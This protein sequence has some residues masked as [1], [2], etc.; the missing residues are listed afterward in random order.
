MFVQ[1]APPGQ[2]F[3]VLGAVGVTG[4]DE[5]KVG[6]VFAALQG[7][8]AFEQ[9]GAGHRGELLAKKADGVGRNIARA[10]V[11]Q[12]N[13]HVTGVQVHRVVGGVNADVNVGVF[14]LKRLQPRDEPHRCKRGP[15]G[16]G[17][18]LAPRT[19]ADQAHGAVNALQR[20]HHGAQQLRPRA[21]EL[22]GAGVPQ[23]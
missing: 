15:G 11:A 13:V 18:A 17:H 1:P 7:F 6:Q 9:P 5:C 19:A 14:T 8:A 12:G 23:K 21:G 4:F 20:G 3:Q 2:P 10:G 16:D 22:H